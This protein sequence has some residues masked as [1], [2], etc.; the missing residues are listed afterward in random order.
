M[1]INSNMTRN[2]FSESILITI[3]GHSMMILMIHPKSQANLRQIM[4]S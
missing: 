4:Q 3:H 1:E 2:T